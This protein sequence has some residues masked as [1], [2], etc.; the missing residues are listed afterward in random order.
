MKHARDWLF[1]IPTLAAFGFV[2]VVFH[3]I[4]L[5]ALP[6]GRRPFE[7][8]MA[9]LQR[10]LI[11][12]FRISGVK[13]TIEGR[14][15]FASSGGYIFVSN[16]Q[17]MY[18][19]PIFGGLLP[20]NYPKYVAKKELA[21][22]IPSVSLNLRSGGNALIDR[23]DRDQSLQAIRDMASEA[24]RRNVSVVIFPE[25]TR[26]RIGELGGFRVGGLATIME[27]A[28]NLS[29]I[30]TAIDG[31]WR[32]FRRNMFPIPYGAAVRVRFS[33]PIVRQAD[34]SPVDILDRCRAWI[35]ATIT[36]WRS[37]TANA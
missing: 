25:G 32:V 17:S 8:V 28:P 7:K 1:S 13:I 3:V 14:D 23:D 21:K 6:F 18:D 16:H 35:E 27:A 29:I 33:E 34:E 10:S 31:S 30:P 11:S 12:S 20:R 19:V 37:E 36:E 26:A 15:R 24:E 2:L 5:I 22:G 4:A 9:A